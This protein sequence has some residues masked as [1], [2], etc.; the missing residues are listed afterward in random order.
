MFFW[1]IQIS[2]LG[3]TKVAFSLNKISLTIFLYCCVVYECEP[4]CKHFFYAIR[5]NF[6]YFNEVIDFSYSR[7]SN[8]IT[9]IMMG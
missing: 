8:K 7:N 5:M 2:I 1:V 3:T 6:Y 9:I 4:L